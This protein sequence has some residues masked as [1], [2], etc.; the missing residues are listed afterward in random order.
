MFVPDANVK[1]V[2]GDQ[3]GQNRHQHLKVVT[4]TCCLQHPSPT[5]M[6]P[7]NSHPFESNFEKLS[8]ANT[9]S[10]NQPESLAWDALI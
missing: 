10:M 3:N 1:R 5:S 2:V 6:L 9:A 8:Y 4:N 7:S